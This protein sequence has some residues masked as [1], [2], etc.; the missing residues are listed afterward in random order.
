M[1]DVPNRDA[2]TFTIRIFSTI[3]TM[4]MMDKTSTYMNKERRTLAKAFG[5]YG[6]TLRPRAKESRP[7][8]VIGFLEGA[9]ELPTT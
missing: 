4:Q 2:Y 1:G 5:H 3:D 6:I 7:E 9:D 8:V